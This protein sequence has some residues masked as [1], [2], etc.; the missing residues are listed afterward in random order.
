MAQIV[1]LNS[2]TGTFP[3]NIWVCDDCSSTATCLYIDTTPT[4]P[5]SFI[6]PSFF[7]ESPSYTIKVIDANNCEYCEINSTYVQF[8]ND[9]IFTFMD[10]T[11]YEFQ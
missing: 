6:L 10:D 9:D 4:L 7:E 2:T 8:M 11:P 3:L 5:Y 1:T